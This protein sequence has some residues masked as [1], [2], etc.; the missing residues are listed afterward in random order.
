V[1]ADEK[2]F[3]KAVEATDIDDAP[4]PAHQAELRRRVLAAFDEAADTSQL[5][6][7]RRWSIRLGRNLM[8]SKWMQIGA[9]AAAAA[10]CVAIAALWALGSGADVALAEV[11]QSIEQAKTVCFELSCYRDGRSEGTAEV[12]FM[13]PG[14]MRSEWRG[15]VSIFDWN[16]GE[17]L[18]L[19]TEQKLAHSSV[20][21][22]MEN[23]YCRNW[24]G[25]LKAIMGS[26]AAEELGRQELLGREVKGWRTRQDG[27]VC[28]V[29][30]DAETGKL[31]QVEFE[32]GS[33]RMVM[34][35]FVLDRE[36]D[37]SL[38]SMSPP[39]DYRLATEVEMSEAD[40]SEQD[41]LALLRVWASGNGGRF[42][43]RLDS[44][45]FGS[46]A[47][48][49]DWRGL[50]IDSQE[51]SQAMREAIFRAFYLLNN[52][53]LEWGYV[54]KGVESGQA[55]QPVFWYRRVG[56]ETYRVIYGDFS[57]GEVSPEQLEQLKQK[58]TGGGS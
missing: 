48:K 14:R 19:M 1:F 45:Q 15:V 49:A 56:A 22:D 27:R 34:S 16:C 44:S 23:P 13:E 57:V 28:T 3:R 32:H 6:R 17:I 10:A 8:H 52:W 58:A 36:L 46:A 20:V 51:K 7:G 39:E 31:R 35:Q 5:W 47:A 11:R 33:N 12:M 40:P 42:P 38:F 9:A 18:V 25:D 41:I 29:W 30:A 24:L 55:D 26:D 4:R 43:D 53:E 21:K 2:E 54:G 37:E 50:G